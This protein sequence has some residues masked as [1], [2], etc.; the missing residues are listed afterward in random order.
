MKRLRLFTCA[1]FIFSAFGAASGHAN[2]DRMAPTQNS[3]NINADD[4]KSV[5]SAVLVA[6][7]RRVV[8]IGEP[9]HGG[10]HSEA[11]KVALI[12]RLVRKCGFN[13]IMFES[14]TYEFLPLQLPQQHQNSRSPI[15]ATS[16]STAVGP[17]WNGDVE[18]AQLFSFLAPLVSK[19]QVRL[20]GLDYQADGRGQTYS[21][22]LLFESLSQSLPESQRERCRTLFQVRI[23]G[24]E[25]GLVQSKSQ[26][27]QE[28]L[29]CLGDIEKSE[30]RNGA[31][32]IVPQ[33]EKAW[34]LKN[35]I[36]WISADA[37]IPP[38]QFLAREKQMTH[39]AISI[40]ASG[41]RYEKVLIWT[42]NIHASRIR[43]SPALANFLPVGA[44]LAEVYGNSYYSIGLTSKF[45]SYRLSSRK[46]RS[47]TTSP[48]NSLEQTLDMKGRSSG[49]FEKQTFAGMG[50]R[51][52]GFFNYEY[53][54]ADWSFAFDGIVV[55]ELEYPP[56]KL[57][58]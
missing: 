48:F 42:H 55:F 13:V 29:K 19:G 12:E 5:E 24:S 37:L 8:A 11:F 2:A 14:S 15:T 6:C 1:S 27:T 10:G 39:N 44:S 50:N 46:Y 38:E 34:A 40:I 7:D 58:L 43:V 57:E 32:N 41:G 16:I 47:I 22:K 9:T 26:L 53:R 36:A 30:S 23:S 18:T 33:N 56:K 52:A 31:S 51:P 45:G 21:N 28:L 35:L 25:T 4:R 20:Y 49:F 3:S 54:E 17:V